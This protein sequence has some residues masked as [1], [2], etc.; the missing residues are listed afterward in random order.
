MGND[1]ATTSQGETRAGGAGDA[2]ILDDDF[3]NN[4]SALYRQL[5]EERPVVRARTPAGL[6]VWIVT[7]FTDVRSVMNDPRVSKDARLSRAVLSRQTHRSVMFTEALDENML[8]SDPPD[9]TR[10]RTL[11]GRAFTKRRIE[12]L[13]PRIEQLTAELADTMDAAGPSVD[14]LDDFALPLPLTVICELLGVPLERRMDFQK[15]TFALISSPDPGERSSA[16]AAIVEFLTALVA[17]KA[18]RPGDDMLSMIATASQ[19]GDRLSQ[20]E[21]TSMA[22]LLL[23]A[24]H[25]TTVNLI[26][27][28]TRALLANLTRLPV[29]TPTPR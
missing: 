27:N 18:A 9:H 26:V 4:R 16:M 1:S 24:G 12:A 13:R 28:G 11:V 25:E 23:V 17:E 5:R 19:E 20:D 10:L 22:F 29:C 14:L 6:S 3:L 8:S 7:R 21:T 2:V 15:W